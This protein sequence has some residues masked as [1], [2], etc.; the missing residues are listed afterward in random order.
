MSTRP[1]YSA[2]KSALPLVSVF[3]EFCWLYPW[4]LLLS[5]AFYGGAAG[6]L[7]GPWI[8]FG[9]LLAGFI[10]VRWA[11]A[12]SWP[13]FTARAVVAVVGLGAGLLAVKRT[14]YPLVAAWDLRWIGSL[15]RAA[16]DAL[17]AFAPPVL[18][19][20][21]VA[22]LWWRG[23]VLGEREFNHFEIDR[24]YRR[25]VAWSIF[26]VLLYALYGRTGGLILTAPVYLLVFFSL[27]LTSLAVARLISIWQ[28]TQADEEQA[29]ATNRHW[30]LLLIG[31]VGV[32]LSLAL[33]ISGVVGVE[34]R[35]IVLA[36]LRPLEP[37]VEFIFYLVFAV[38]LV[39]A[40]AILFVFSQLPFR[41]VRS[42]LPEATP[43]SFAEL[44]R[45]LPP[46]VVSGARW[47]MVLVVLLLL[48]LLVA[49]AV[50][51]ARRRSRKRDEDERESVWSAEAVF[52]GFGGMWRSL[53]NRLRSPARR[54][55]EPAVGAIRTLYRELLRVG[56]FLDTPRFGYETP[57][58]YR[59]RLAQRV[60]EHNSDVDALTEIYVKVRYAAHHAT[61]DDVHIGQARLARIKVSAGLEQ[62]SA[63]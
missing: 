21:L 31:V 23:I 5:G 27:G 58:E 8:T 7:L 6:A 4:L 18:G 47:G 35:P 19:A 54:Y 61:T 53:M 52:A 3:L 2:I 62:G 24:Q 34:F 48:L 63:S 59:P 55:E 39:I 38:A 57:Y 28:E 17:P 42:T 36:V 26:F 45:S 51:R 25:G 1:P 12:R 29:L 9:L 20:L 10:T 22:L 33:S 41:R 40:R 13:I 37:V 60:P 46:Q 43:P 32:I 44:F 14:Y 30:I 56:A 11:L 15:L 49:I 50:V 16:H